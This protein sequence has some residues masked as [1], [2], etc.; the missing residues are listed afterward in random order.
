MAIVKGSYQ[1]NLRVVADEPR[2]RFTAHLISALVIL[3]MGVG[4]YLYGRYEQQTDQQYAQA[5][6]GDMR[7]KL[8][9]KIGE[10]E[11]YRQEVENL[12]LGAQVDQHANENVRQ[13]V[14]Q[15]KATIAE[16]EE[17]V[18][19]YRGLMSPTVNKRG[20]TIGSLDV[21]ATG[22]P[23][24]Y[25]YKLVIQQLASNHRQLQGNAEF[26]V[27]GRDSDGSVRSIALKDLSPDVAG[28]QI[29]LRFKY[30]QNLAGEMVLP[31]GF[32]PERIELVAKSTGKDA[33]EVEKK[34][35]WLVQQS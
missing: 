27:V 23:R 19:F 7:V 22:A 32:T 9:S 26:T 20:L 6:V 31:E 2:T 11:Q 3:T 35:G 18:T 34:F 12:R 17:N 15:L 14:I 10:A 5:E 8:H 4:G 28:E 16:L 1:Y 21:I 33:V 24:H 13:E 29:R 30:F 25:Q